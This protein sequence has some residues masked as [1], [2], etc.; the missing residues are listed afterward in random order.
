MADALAPATRAPRSRTSGLA[1]AAGIV[2]FGF[3][4]SRL[5]GVLRTVAIA[6]AF[7]ASPELDAYWVAF[8]IPD[9]I[10][11]V[12]AGATLGSAFI[13][14]FARLYRRDGEERAWRLASTVLNL[15]T[16]AT[17]A[18]CVVAFVF[19]PLIVPL[20]AP[21]LGTEIGRH[22]ELTD[23]AV[24]LTRL[25]LLSPLLF[26]ISGMVTGI[27]NARERFLLPA[28]APMLYNLA[29]IFGAVVLS[30]PFGVE[31][32]AVG[33]VAGAALHLLVQIPGL[34]RE[35]MRYRRAFDWHNPATR[36]V[37]RLMGPRVVGL[38]AAQVN[39]VVNTY[40]AS[41]IG[42]S[43]ISNLTYAWLLAGLPLAL[44]GMAISTAVFPRLANQVADGDLTALHATLSR[45]LRVIMF[46]TV[47][48]A[49]GL[50]LL[51]VPVTTI[52]LERGEFTGQDTAVTAGILAVFCLGVVPQAGIEIHSRGY[53]ALG[54]T[55]TPVILAVSSM[56]LN[57]ALS[58]LLWRRFDERGLA[59]ADSVTAWLEW[60]ALYA[61]FTRRAGTN[62]RA[63][64]AALARFALCAAVMALFL[65]LAFAGFEREGRL[66]NGLMAVTGAMAGV[67]VYG[68]MAH[69]LRLP[70]LG[71]AVAR[72]RGVLLRR[73]EPPVPEPAGDI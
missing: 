29:I 25:M 37:G 56:L 51:R 59:F 23:K 7:G 1:I 68:A 24:S 45:A 64:L 34:V 72:F 70:E 73:A 30:A 53:Y 63:D 10:F 41:K 62:V 12:L 33:V 71:E 44:F 60:V 36:E 35:G 69:W 65:A 27:L 40:F 61:L 43:S 32:L 19:A 18:L 66:A 48:A 28:L 38:A 9:L 15:V 13:P 49:L 6:D 42:P 67:A 39:F 14:V 47:P 16:A 50:A 21:G 26:S 3:I 22:D 31:G 20:L 52:L 5:L 8:R 11:Q 17:A 58:A 2:A 46:L 55:R 4:G 54:D 57:F